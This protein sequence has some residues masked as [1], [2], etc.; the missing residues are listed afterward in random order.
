MPSAPLSNSR[1]ASE[2]SPLGILAIGAMPASSAAMAICDAVSIDIALCSRSRKSQSKPAV[3][4]AL[5]IS[6][7]RAARTPNPSESSPRSSRSRALL[8]TAGGPEEDSGTSAR[9]VVDQIADI[10][11]IGRGDE[12]VGGAARDRHAVIA[13]HQQ[14]SLRLQQHEGDERIG[15]LA[16]RPKKALVAFR[17]DDDHHVGGGIGLGPRDVAP[18][19]RAAAGPHLDIGQAAIADRPRD[20]GPGAAQAV[21][22]DGAAGR[23]AVMADAPAGDRAQI[24]FHRVHGFPF[25]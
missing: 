18:A 4:I 7:E 6:T 9:Q 13:H 8:R 5:A 19:D 12:Q 22:L 3:F 15:P 23:V 21:E 16:F 10:I 17:A 20:G 11:A 2:Y 14:V 24:G 25:G 1:V